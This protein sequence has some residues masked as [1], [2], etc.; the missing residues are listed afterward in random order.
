MFILFDFDCYRF[1]VCEALSR[2]LEKPCGDE[3]RDVNECDFR[4]FILV[5]QQNVLR[6]TTAFHSSSIQVS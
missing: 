1:H 3:R 4:I 6:Y 5:S 2:R